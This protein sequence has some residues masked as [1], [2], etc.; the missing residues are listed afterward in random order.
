MVVQQDSSW[1]YASCVLVAVSSANFNMNGDGDDCVLRTDWHS[2]PVH[3]PDY[4][5]RRQ[6][7][8][9]S[10]LAWHALCTV[11][12]AASVLYFV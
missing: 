6:L 8:E 2:M 4:A 3:Y 1:I 9:F 5:L 12:C 7:L 11:C 10:K